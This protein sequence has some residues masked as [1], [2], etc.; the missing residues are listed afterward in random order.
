MSD[1]GAFAVGGAEEQDGGESPPLKG[2]GVVIG[3]MR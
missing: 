2:A 1:P 3:L